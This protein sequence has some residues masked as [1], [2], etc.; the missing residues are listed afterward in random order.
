[1]QQ[2]TR[3]CEQAL[4]VT[5]DDVF[6]VR[7]HRRP[8]LW[9]LEQL[10]LFLSDVCFEAFVKCG[11]HLRQA[12]HRS[13]WDRLDRHF[14]SLVFKR[15]LGHLPSLDLALE[16]CHRGHTTLIDW[17]KDLL[18]LDCTEFKFRIF[19]LRNRTFHELSGCCLVI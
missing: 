2:T 7:R 14:L 16:A 3:G 18:A 15:S 11:M 8:H 12:Q 1:M 6:Y 9:V 4:V 13:L 19:T 5:A 17:W 10:V